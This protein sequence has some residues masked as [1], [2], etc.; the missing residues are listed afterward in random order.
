[1]KIFEFNGATEFAEFI[2]S[3]EGAVLAELKEMIPMS[4]NFATLHN[5]MKAKRPCACGGLSPEEA[6][7]KREERFNFLYKKFLQD[8]S[9]EQK[10]ALMSTIKDHKKVENIKFKQSFN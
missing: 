10:D 5:A 9:Q 1:M 8:L 3:E 7:K 4:V 6:I 2:V